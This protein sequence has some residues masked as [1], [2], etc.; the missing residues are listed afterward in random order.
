MKRVV[1]IDSALRPRIKETDDLSWQMPAMRILMVTDAWHPQVNGV[2]R[3][4][5]RLSQDPDPSTV[6]TDFLTPA[7][8]RTL[9]L[10]IL[11][12]HPAGA[13]HASATSRGASKRAIPIISISSTEGPLGFLARRFCLQGGPAVH[14]ELS[15]ALSGI[16]ARPPAHPGSWTYRWL[17]RFPQCRAAARWSQRQSLARRTDGARLRQCSGH[18]RAASI[19]TISG[20]TEQ[21]ALDLPRPIFLSVGRVAVEKN[22]PAFLDLDLPGSKVVVG[23]GPALARLK[24]QISATPT[25]SATAPA[26]NLPISTPLPMSSCF[27]AGPTR[28]ASCFLEALASGMP[29][30]AYPV[31]G[32]LDILGD[33]VG[34][35]VSNDLREAALAA[36]D[37][38]PRRRRASGQCAVRWNSLR[39]EMSPAKRLDR[40]HGSPGENSTPRFSSSPARQRANEKRRTRRSE[41]CS[42]WARKL[43]VRTACRRPAPCARSR[44]ARPRL[45][46]PGKPSVSTSDMNL[47]IWR[48]GKLTTAKT[49]RPTASR[50]CSIW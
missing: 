49:C 13:D 50:A 27:P 28:S 45:P 14:D 4:L 32:P 46:R 23:D 21:N 35:A 20:R 24:A 38:E 15:H 29:V 7:V 2:V 31:T 37:V 26:T 10:P 33:G 30:A 17:R 9:P 19:P 12:G 11:S 1:L 42:R 8:F 43:I 48:G 18:G 22:L 34:G 16:S 6:E 25:S 44:R 47:P 36:L 41:D 3:T 5:E 39:S 40:A